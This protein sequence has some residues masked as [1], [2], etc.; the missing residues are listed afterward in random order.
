MDSKISKYINGSS[1]TA[2]MQSK[3]SKILF[4]KPQEIED[5][6]LKISEIEEVISNNICQID[7]L[8]YD[9]YQIIEI[10]GLKKLFKLKK[11]K[12]QKEELLSKIKDLGDEIDNLNDYVKN[13]KEEIDVIQTEIDSFID[14]IHRDG[15]SLDEIMFAYQTEKD[16]LERKAR[17]EYVEPTFDDE[18]L[19]PEQQAVSEEPKISEVKASQ[20][21]VEQKKEERLEQNQKKSHHLS[22][23]EKFEKRLAR[24]EEL[25]R[26][27]NSEGQGPQNY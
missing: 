5:K 18:L 25:S 8:Q 7:V 23:R 27:N 12:T 13:L 15:F 10:K 24:T 11:I 14:E 9:L 4:A 21:Y 3:T 16:I 17:G 6:K 2:L 1:L 22:P 19:I 26:K 20:T